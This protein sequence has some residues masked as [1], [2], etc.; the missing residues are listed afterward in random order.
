ML[1]IYVVVFLIDK[2]IVKIQR[3][4]LTLHKNYARFDQ[5]SLIEKLGA[6]DQTFF[7][8]KPNAQQQQ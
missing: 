4:L 1:S 8:L 6:I 3:M 5:I 7:K 2:D